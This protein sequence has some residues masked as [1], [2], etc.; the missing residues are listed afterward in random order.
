VNIDDAY[1]E[2]G[3]D[4]PA[5]AQ[6]TRVIDEDDDEAMASVPVTGLPKPDTVAAAVPAVAREHGLTR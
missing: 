5:D 4:R 2:E 6:G 3:D 1:H